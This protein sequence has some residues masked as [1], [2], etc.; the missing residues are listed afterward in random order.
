MAR[1]SLFQRAIEGTQNLISRLTG[2]RQINPPSSTQSKSIT[3]RIG[4][5]GAISSGN[6]TR[7][8]EPEVQR[9]AAEHDLEI[10]QL[11]AKLQPIIDEANKRWSRLDELDLRSL[12]IS[13]AY[14]ESNEQW[15]F[16]VSRLT[17]RG[18]II[19]EATRAR[20]FINDRTSTP[21]GAELYS[22]QESYK[23]WQGQF[24]NQYNNWENKFKKFNITTISEDRARVAFAAYRRLEESEAARIMSYG[25]ENMII[26]IYDMVVHQGFTDSENIDDVTDITE[27]ARDLLSRELGEKRAEF[28]R[29]FKESNKVGDILD[30]VQVQDD[31][32]GRGRW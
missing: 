8:S 1:K 20:V 7:P 9:K 21:E 11:K 6:E 4:T 14:D 15:G 22:Q 12:A 18:E 25:S 27:Q 5:G 23:Q 26:A 17:D 31:Y 28:E 2:S 13:R 29:A 24:G 32:L 16:D 10:N 3:E 19:A 30:I